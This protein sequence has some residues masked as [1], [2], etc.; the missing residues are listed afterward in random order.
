MSKSTKE[1]KL[2]NTWSFKDIDIKDDTLI[3][4]INLKPIIVP[5]SCGR[6][7]HKRFWKSNISVTERLLNRLLS[8]GFIGGKIKGHKSS[9]Q[10]GKKSKLIKSLKTA[11]TLIDYITGENPI[12]VLVNAIT[13]TAP[14]EETT[15]IAMGGI[16]YAS[17]VDIAPQRRVDLALKYLVQAIAGRSSNSLKAF[18]ENLA[19]ELI[20]ASKNSQDSRAVKRKDEIERIAV[21]AR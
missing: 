1:I 5:H 10:S 8:P 12:Q 16:S 17:A 18:E 19:Q 15:R 21:S 4:Y 7:E 2:F 13:N 20:M 14:R 6:H 3:S 9:Y 11:F